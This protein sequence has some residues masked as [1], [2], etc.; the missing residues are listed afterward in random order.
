MVWERKE[1][2]DF[3]ISLI[4]PHKCAAC[5]K[6]VPG[7]RAEALCEYCDKHIVPITEPR[8]KRCSKPIAD[9]TCEFCEDCEKRHFLVESGMALYPYDERMQRVIRQFK[10]EGCYEIGDFF[11]MRMGKAF[12]KWIYEFQPDVI[13]PVPVHKKRLRFRGFNQAEVLA[14]GLGDYLNIPVDAETLIRT[15]DTKPQKNLDVHKRI[16]NLQ[17]GFALDSEVIWERVLLVDDIYTTGA[18]LEACARVL[19]QA[20]VRHIRFVCLCIGATNE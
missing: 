6:I 1:M 16:A 7:M 3:L 8:C 5:G 20:G 2:K 18:T 10:Y 11:A 17:K 9:T 12:Y 19:Q 13:L 4:F 14:E 15:E